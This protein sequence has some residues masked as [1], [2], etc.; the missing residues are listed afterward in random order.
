MIILTGFLRLLGTGPH[1]VII[2][3]HYG[4]NLRYFTD[5][6]FTYLLMLLFHFLLFQVLCICHE[7]N[8][9]HIITVSVIIMWE[10]QHHLDLQLL[11]NPSGDIAN[12]KN[13]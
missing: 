3:C 11:F 4:T 10:E 13:Y 6:F 1:N 7:W 9:E 12:G 2:N 8:V 5:V